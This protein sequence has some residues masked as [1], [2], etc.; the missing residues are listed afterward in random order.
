MHVALVLVLAIATASAQDTL[1]RCR[2][3]FA[4]EH[5]SALSVDAQCNA[6]DKFDLCLSNNVFRG[7]SSC[8]CVHGMIITGSHD[9]ELISSA[10]SHLSTAILE[11]FDCPLAASMLLLYSDI[12]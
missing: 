5:A 2:D 4:S 8:W 6:L 10:E 7:T 12:R 3:T 9:S 11:N 1:T